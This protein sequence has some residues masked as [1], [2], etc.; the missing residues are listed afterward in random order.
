ME[1]N[2]HFITTQRPYEEG[3]VEVFRQAIPAGQVKQATLTITAL[4]VYEAELDGVKVGDALLTPGFTFYPRDLHC[5]TY[6]VTQMVRD[7]SV[8]TVYLG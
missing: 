2:N 3:V 4:G 6:D 8:L 5:Q 7:G 1:L